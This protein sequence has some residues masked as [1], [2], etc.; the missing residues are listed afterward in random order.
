MTRL[1][2]SEAARQLG[3]SR[4]YL[5]KL[6]NDGHVSPAPDG[7]ID[8]AELVRVAPLVDNAKKQL[9]TS[10]DTTTVDSEN[11]EDDIDEVSSD[12]GNTVVKPVHEQSTTDVHGQAF[13]AIVDMLREQLQGAQ[14]RER[15]YQAQIERLTHMLQESQQHAQRLLPAPVQ[16]GFWARIF[17][18]KPS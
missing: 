8:T 3:I 5:Y 11:R 9:R 12:T 14:E 4:T 7:M 2:K 16:Q 10:T 18:R 13:T 1:T 6:I 17:R 15:H